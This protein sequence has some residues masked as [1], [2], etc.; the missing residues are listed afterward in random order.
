MRRAL[1][2]IFWVI[3]KIIKCL[4]FVLLAIALWM[5]CLDWLTLTYVDPHPQQIVRYSSSHRAAFVFF[6]G[7][8]S[9]GQAHSAPLRDLWSDRYD[10]VVVEYNRVRFDGRVT[11]YDTYQ[12]LRAWGYDRVILDGASMGGLLA[13]DVIDFDHADSGQ[14]IEFAVML[15]DAP[16]DQQDL[17]LSSRPKVA[18]KLWH[19]GVVTNLVSGWFWDLFFSPP[20]R[21]QLGSGVNNQQ[22]ETHY[23]ASRTYPLSGWVGELR[24]MTGHRGFIRNQ[25]QGIPLVVMKSENDTTVKAN[26]DRW[27]EIFG[28]GTLVQVP[29]TTHVGFV[30]YP[31]RW[32]AAFQKGFAALPPGW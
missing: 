1:R 6:T 4:L 7:V 3:G 13:T 23:Q 29:Q 8:Q 20:P 18:S 30:E 10:V 11:A 31:D 28:G 15:Q 32:R 16:V 12:Q 22:L 2:R 5:G 9:S 19:P 26:F 25:Y 24:Y 17:Y 27:K 14:H 21:D